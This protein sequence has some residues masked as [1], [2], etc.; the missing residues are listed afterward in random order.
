MIVHKVI[1]WVC[2]GWYEPGWQESEW[3]EIDGAEPGR[4]EAVVASSTSRRSS[5][6]CR[7]ATA[8]S[9][10]SGCSTGSSPTRSRTQLGKKPNAVY[11]A[12]HRIAKRL[13]EWLEA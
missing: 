2:K 3:I 9:R 5:R 7:P 12:T 8:R 11:Q 1:G 13:R 10:G 6:R 4:A